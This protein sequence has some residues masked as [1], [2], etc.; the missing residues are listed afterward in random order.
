M[1]YVYIGY[2][3]ATLSVLQFIPYIY[4]FATEYRILHVRQGRILK[5]LI[6][7]DL[8]FFT[9]QLFWTIY[10]FAMGSVT[11]IVPSLTVLVSLFVLIQFWFYNR[12]SL[13]SR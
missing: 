8:L 2:I 6:W 1:W 13:R 7:T 5:R 3:A 12:H 4:E 9:T 11:V 10:G